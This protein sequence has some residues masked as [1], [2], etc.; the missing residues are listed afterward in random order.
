MIIQPGP[1]AGQPVS[2][3]SLGLLWAGWPGVKVTCPGDLGTAGFG[4]V[5][6]EGLGLGLGGFPV[7]RLWG[8]PAQGL[9]LVR[10]LT[11]PSSGCLAPREPHLST[12]PAASVAD[13]SVVRA[14]KKVITYQVLGQNQPRKIVQARFEVTDVTLIPFSQH[15]WSIHSMLGIGVPGLN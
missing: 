2:A 14:R 13:P 5:T 7:T 12:L 1:V 6:P 8:D 15:L 11:C 3:G 9:F 10:S 4:R